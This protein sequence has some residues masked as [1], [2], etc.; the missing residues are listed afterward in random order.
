MLD[1]CVQYITPSL[2]ELFA[3]D[4]HGPIGFVHSCNAKFRNDFYISFPIKRSP[5]TVALFHLPRYVKGA[6]IVAVTLYG[7]VKKNTTLIT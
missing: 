6:T 1:L 4:C 5:Q 7:N 3:I 2:A